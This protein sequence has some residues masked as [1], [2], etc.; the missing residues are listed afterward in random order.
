MAKYDRISDSLTRKEQILG[1]IWLVFQL[2]FLP[3]LLAAGNGW[4]GNPLTNATVNFLY[5][6][7][8]FLGVVLIFH[9]FL[10]KNVISLGKRFFP[11]IQGAFL[12]FFVYYGSTTLLNQVI[13]S[14]FP[15]FSNVNDAN[16]AS[17]AQLHYLTMVIGT[18][19]LVPVAE[20][21]LHRGLVFGTLYRKHRGLGYA[22]S[23][24]LFCAVHVVG[25]VGKT[26]ALTLCLCFVQYIPASL[27]LSWAYVQG[28]NIVTPILMHMVINAMGIY[29]VR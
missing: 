6:V 24:C 15:G 25:Y 16:V 20:E 11:C 5:F 26:D 17:M 27:C 14:L 12:G 1:W 2:C 13:Y 10:G 22:L 3:T 9:Q 28:D 18:V 8:N 21:V 19:F 23:A 29:A 7:L 4:L